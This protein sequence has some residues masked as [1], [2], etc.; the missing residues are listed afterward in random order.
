[1]DTTLRQIQGGAPPREV[2]VVW[3]S[4]SLPTHLRE[5]IDAVK[6]VHPGAR[7]VV[8]KI[9]DG[10]VDRMLGYLDMP[11]EEVPEIHR[12]FIALLRQYGVRELP[13]LIVDGRL[14]AVG[15]S[16]AEVL[17]RLLYTPAIA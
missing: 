1:M 8:V 3:P 15:Y 2:I 9:R 11:D 12:S 10:D 14:V 6:R 4:T 5:A 7:V 17:R 13:A 16:V